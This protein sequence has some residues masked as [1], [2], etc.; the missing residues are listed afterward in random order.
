MSAILQYLQSHQSEMLADLE[1]LVKAESPSDNKE[2]TDKCGKVLQA[3]FAKHLGLTADIF[4]REHTGD[5]LRFTY[6]DGSEQILILSH[7]DTVWDQGQLHFRVEG[8]RAFGPGI[9]DMKAGIIQAIWALKACKEL[10][11]SFNKKIVFLCTSDEETGSLSSRKLIEQEAKKS[12]VV[13][14][15]EFAVR[16][17]GALKTER[18]GVGDFIFTI[19]GLAAH[20]GNHHEDGVS[21][22]EEM[23]HQILWLN[24]FTDY[25]AGTTINV[26][27][28][29]GGTRP[30]VVAD[31]AELQVDLRFS[32]PLAGE[33]IASKIL[34]AKA[35]LPKA[36]VKVTGGINR[37]PMVKTRST[38]ELFEMAY[39][40]GKQIG[41]TLT[42]TAVGGG[43]DGNFTAALGIPTLDGLGAMGDGAHAQ[44][45][46][47]LIDQLP[48]RSALMS[49]LVSR[50]SE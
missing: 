6:G 1:E 38:K 18:K 13:L 4:R 16:G 26:G 27:V 36:S 35:F 7:F 49:H 40:C 22:V 12:S 21:A 33:Q 14:V 5:H 8:N 25:T 41:I 17:T 2:L 43:S 42:E 47:I 23:A 3:I 20:A 24:S 29:R 37:P 32:D 50:L 46:H 9:Y 31:K 10:G 30:N 45:E 28:A 11:V 48:V 34:K 19:A 15:T 39:D 44:N